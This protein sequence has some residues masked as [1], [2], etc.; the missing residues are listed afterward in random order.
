MKIRKKVI[1]FIE[2][3]QSRLDKEAQEW[4]KEKLETGGNNDYLASNPYSAE[5]EDALSHDDTKHPL[6]KGT[7]KSL[8]Y[9][10]KN[11]KAPKNVIAH[12]DINTLEGGGSIDKETR[13]RLQMMN[14]YKPG[15]EYGKNSVDIDINLAGQY[16]VGK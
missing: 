8:D 15:K 12:S 3:K 7:G 5:H 1:R 14:E 9:V 2:M 11:E 16:F 6:G 10:V 4:R 13:N